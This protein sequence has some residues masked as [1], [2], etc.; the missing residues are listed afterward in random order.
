MKINFKV[1]SIISLRDFTKE[2]IL[3]ILDTAK[4]IDDNRKKYQTHKGKAKRRGVEFSLT[5]EEWLSIWLSSVHLSERGRAVNQYCM[6]RKLDKGGYTVGNVR[7]RTVKH[8]QKESSH[9]RTSKSAHTD[10]Q[11]GSLYFGDNRILH[12]YSPYHLMRYEEKLLES[13]DN[14]K[15]GFLD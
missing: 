2:E 3:Y 4:R 13:H 15:H 1:R 6:C 12:S 9:S 7:I 10:V 8:N 5:F 11:I 14:D